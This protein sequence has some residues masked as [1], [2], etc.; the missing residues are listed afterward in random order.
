M[1]KYVM[2]FWV[3]RVVYGED[4]SWREIIDWKRK[5]SLRRALVG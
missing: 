5:E 1:Y 2:D 4:E 3:E